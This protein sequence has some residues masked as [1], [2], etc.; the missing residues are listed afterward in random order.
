M[1]FLV[2]TLAKPGNRIIRIYK[3]AKPP[4]AVYSHEEVKRMEH[5]IVVALGIIS[6]LIATGI[7][8]IIRRV[9]MK[10]SPPNPE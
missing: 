4:S 2:W 9:T 8:W 1:L 5:L 3:R 6:S 7:Q 10:K